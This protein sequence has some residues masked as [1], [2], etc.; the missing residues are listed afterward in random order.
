MTSILYAASGDVTIGASKINGSVTARNIS[1]ESGAVISTQPTL[2]IVDW[3]SYR[4]CYVDSLNNYV[5]KK[6]TVKLDDGDPVHHRLLRLV[7]EWLTRPHRL[8]PVVCSR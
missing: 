4:A 2:A 8:A 6:V 3:C 1:A 7:R 5:C